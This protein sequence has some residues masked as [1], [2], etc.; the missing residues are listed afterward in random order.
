[1]PLLHLIGNWEFHGMRGP[2]NFTQA[3]IVGEVRPGV[4]GATMWNLGVWG[5][6]FDLATVRFVANHATAIALMQNY[7]LASKQNPM[8]LVYGGQP[9][10]GGLF[11]VQNVEPIQATAIARGQ[12]PG[13]PTWYQGIVRARWTLFPLAH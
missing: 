13:D 2:P 3:I 1:M 4:N 8:V 6:P 7:M 9:V 12:V 5:R 11:Q 10:Q